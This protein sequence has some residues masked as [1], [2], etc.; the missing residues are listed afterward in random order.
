MHLPLLK[1]L[2]PDLSAL[3][4]K[5]AMDPVTAIANVLVSINT[6]VNT[7]LSKASSPE[8]DALIQSHINARQKFEDWLGKL[9]H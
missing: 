8:I 3:R 6:I 7:L 4:G 9:I 2:I 5:I 1:N